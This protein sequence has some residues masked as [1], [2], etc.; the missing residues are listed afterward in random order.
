[1]AENSTVYYKRVRGGSPLVSLSGLT[2]VA[3]KAHLLAKL[4]AETGRSF[5]IVTESNS[6]LETW[7]SDLRYFTS[8]DRLSDMPIISLPSFETD[9]YSGASPHAETQERRALAL[10]QLARET[11]GFVVLSARSLIQRT[12]APQEIATL[13]CT[14]KL[15]EDFPPEMLVETLIAGGYVREEP[16]F[17]PGQFSVR[18]G[19]VDVWSPDA[20]VSCSHRI[21]WRHGRID[22]VIRSGHSAF[23]RTTPRDLDRPDA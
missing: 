21:F 17:G 13:G 11:A 20:T 6:E 9:P 23:D 1:M 19:I 8:A 12:V 15:D 18:G 7:A 2:S 3:A 22:P 5:A 16:L 4:Q 10:W 14:L